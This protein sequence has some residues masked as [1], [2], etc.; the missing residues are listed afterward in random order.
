MF[1]FNWGGARG[2]PETFMQDAAYQLDAARYIS[3]HFLHFLHLYN[4]ETYI[5]MKHLFW[6]TYYCHI[7]IHITWLFIVWNHFVD[8]KILQ[9][10]AAF[11]V[12]QASKMHK[13]KTL[14]WQSS[15]MY[16]YTHWD[17]VS[18]SWHDSYYTR[19]C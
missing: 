10:F 9:F 18:F 11:I 14:P 8:E 1:K 2:N 19:H 16:D 17:L 13:L 3:L 4:Y 15:F 12:S 6:T 7:Q 5:I